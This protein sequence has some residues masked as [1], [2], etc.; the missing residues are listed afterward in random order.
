[1]ARSLDNLR[2]AARIPHIQRACYRSSKSVGRAAVAASVKNP[3]S[4]P[5]QEW[6][7][8][9]ESFL[10]PPKPRNLRFRPEKTHHDIKTSPARTGQEEVQRR[11]LE[12]QAARLWS[13]AKDGLWSLHPE[14]LP[15]RPVLSSTDPNPSDVLYILGLDAKARL[16]ASELKPLFASVRLLHPAHGQLK[17]MEYRGIHEN[18]WDGSTK[19]A[20]E[21]KPHPVDDPIRN[22]ILSGSALDSVRRMI[23]LRHRIDSKTAVCLMHDGFGVAEA[24]NEQVFDDGGEKPQFILGQFNH[25]LKHTQTRGGL[26]STFGD[27]PPESANVAS[28]VASRIFKTLLV[29]FDPNTGMVPLEN[30]LESGDL[31]DRFRGAPVLNARRSP[32][33]TWVHVKLVYMVFRTVVDPVC[34]A[35]DLRY[36]QVMENGHAAGLIDRLLD[37][38]QLISSSLPEFYSSAQSPYIQS[39]GQNVLRK[40]C[41]SKL[42]RM[43]AQVD[44]ITKQICDG[45]RMDIEYFNG[46]FVRRAKA[47]GLSHYFNEMLMIMLK[48]KHRR[49]FAELHDA[50]PFESTSRLGPGR[51]FKERWM[52]GSGERKSVDV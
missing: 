43:G 49:K 37:E 1:V 21:A 22:I 14:L 29:P 25:G 16:L 44:P 40:V 52:G 30:L 45:R 3:P 39:L 24:V 26:V 23:Q 13:R 28:P 6:R 18:R 12:P 8:R 33:D 32:L 41:F 9:R 15:P 4:T 34:A 5:R 51:P 36:N 7:L 48:A 10:V 50:I 27:E 19:E 31:I 35:L 38:V 17:E 42:R 11:A 47:L 46:Y 20:I 2:A